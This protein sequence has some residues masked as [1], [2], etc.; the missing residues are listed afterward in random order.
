MTAEILTGL[1]R[2]GVATSVAAILAL[3]LRKPL[4]HW[5]GARAAYAIW[6]LMPAAAIAALIPVPTNETILPVVSSAWIGIPRSMTTMLAP[7]SG[8][9]ASSV[10]F[11]TWILGLLCAAGVFAG[12]QARFNRFVQRREDQPYDEVIG[13][14]PAVTGLWRQRI[15]LPTDF[16]HRYNDAEQALVLAHEQ[17]HLRRG[18][19]HA[20]TLAT[21]LRCVFW[22]NPLLHFAV[23]RFRFDQ[24]LACD[25][26]VLAQYPTSRR[27][28]GEAMLKTQMA[29]F[30]LPIGCHWQSSHPLKERIAMLKKPLPGI[31]RRTSG[32]ILVAVVVL[33]GSYSAWAAQPAALAHDTTHAVAATSTDATPATAMT[34]PHYPADAIARKIGGRVVLDLLV[35]ADGTVKNVKVKSSKPSGVFDKVAVEAASKWKFNPS[36]SH[37]KAVEGWVQVPID[38]APDSKKKPTA[39]G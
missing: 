3:L 10:L 16:R 39:A 17:V 15:V 12:R 30:G 21:L 33:A 7:A 2:S 18:D 5:L 20:Q 11:A 24:E 14:G 28:Y 19:V 8:T 26:A 36:T 9:D 38:F 6:A 13:H 35:G 32:S 1:L 4:R 27:S 23:A 25:A 29:E 37:G 22:F 31:V 34:P